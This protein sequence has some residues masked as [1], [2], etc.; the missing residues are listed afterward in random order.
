MNIDN[1]Y[2]IHLSITDENLAALVYSFAYKDNALIPNG[3]LPAN[4][5]FFQDQMR[6]TLSPQRE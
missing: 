5:L 2:D 1:A 3:G 4:M 6:I